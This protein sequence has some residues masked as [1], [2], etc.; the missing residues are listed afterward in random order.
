[1][2]RINLF[3]REDQ[4][5]SIKLLT[6]NLSERIRSAIDYYLRAYHKI[7]KSPSKGGEKSGRTDSNEPNPQ[8]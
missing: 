2:K 4:I 8:G 1:M 5:A 7:S 3:I 6:G